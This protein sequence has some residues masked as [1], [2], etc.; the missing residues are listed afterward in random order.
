MKKNLQYMLDKKRAGTPITV[1]TAYDFPTAQILDEAGIDAVLIGDSVGTNCLGYQNEREVTMEDMAHHTSAVSRGVR[2]ALVI[3][4][5]PYRGADN[6]DDALTNAKRL[7]GCG[8]D[9]VKV[10]G[11]GEMADIVKALRGGGFAVCAHIGYNPQIHDK[12]RVFGKD[13][14]QAAALFE[15]RKRCATPARGLSCWRWC[16]LNSPAESAPNCQY[17]QSESAAA[18][19]ATGRY[20]S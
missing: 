19:G 6:I 7:V 3:A 14:E 11:W 4:D 12:P 9:C 18:T 2:D 16:P 15:A 13:A 8:A 17:R 5:L 1:V 20:W 10:E